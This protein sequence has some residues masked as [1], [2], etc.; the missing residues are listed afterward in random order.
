[1]PWI[2]EIDLSNS[3]DDLKTSQSV[4]GLE[5]D[6]FPFALCYTEF[7]QFVWLLSRKLVGVFSS[8]ALSH[9]SHLAVADLNG[10]TSAGSFV[11]L[12]TVLRPILRVP[13]CLFRQPDQLIGHPWCADFIWI[14]MGDRCGSKRSGR[15]IHRLA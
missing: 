2:R 8:Y 15:I 7:E 9:V 6:R 10:V 3:I 5:V 12:S 11:F 14:W 13:R 4:A 1:M